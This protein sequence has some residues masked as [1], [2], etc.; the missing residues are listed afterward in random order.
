[1]AEAS[2]VQK[3]G[4]KAAA[5]TEGKAQ[6][7]RDNGT[8][9]IADVVVSKISAIAAR[10]VDGVH[11]LV[12]GSFGASVSGLAQRAVGGGSK[13]TGVKVE[14]GQKEA[15]IDLTV[16]VEYGANIVQV[17]DG[18]RD[19]IIDR[20]QSMTGLIVKEVNIGVSDLYFEEDE[21]AEQSEPRVE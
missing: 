8:T 5:R 4:S 11:D 21:K 12:A 9:T 14:V 3:T 10:E 16:V 1:M 13:S 2:G 19:N 20:V 15:A 17:S 7:V 6:L 18:I